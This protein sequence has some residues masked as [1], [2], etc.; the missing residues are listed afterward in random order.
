MIH[1]VPL[2]LSTAV[3]LLAALTPPAGADISHS[4]E[5]RF[6]IAYSQGPG[7]SGRAE[8]L[9]E[10]RYTTTIDHQAD[11][12][13]RFRFELGVLFGNIDPDRVHHSPYESRA[14]AAR[15]RN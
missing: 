3:S 1:K 10:G 13:M 6:G 15:R 5:G 4:V 7:N 9:F 12:G 8:P 14:T 2:A 11:N